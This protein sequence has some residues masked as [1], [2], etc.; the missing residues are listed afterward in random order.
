MWTCRPTAGDPDPFALHKL[1][2]FPQ[3][4][5]SL[6]TAQPGPLHVVITGGA[7]V[8]IPLT[9]PDNAHITVGQGQGQVQIRFKVRVKIRVE[10]RVTVRATVRFTVS[11]AVGVGVG[12]GIGVGVG[13]VGV[14]ARVSRCCMEGYTS[15]VGVK[16]HELEG[17]RWKPA[18]CFSTMGAN[19]SHCRCRPSRLILDPNPE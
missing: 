6:G 7:Y 18:G 1:L 16:R 17:L 3:H 14:K 15:R 2:R 13:W 12:V 8:S 4:G 10:I 11:V 19:V 9:I 5:A